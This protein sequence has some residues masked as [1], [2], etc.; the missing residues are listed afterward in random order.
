MTHISPP[1]L[2]NTDTPFNAVPFH[3]LDAS[4]IQQA[5]NVAY[6][7]A[8]KKFDCILKSDLPPSFENT[9]V[10][11]EEMVNE[12]SEIGLVLFNLNSAAT[13]KEIQNVSLKI[14]PKLTV[15][16]ARLYS[17][18]KL[19]KKVSYLYSKLSVLPISNEEKWIVELLWH[20]MKRNGANLNALSKFRLVHI[21]K[22]LSK[23][24]LHFNDNVLAE[25][26]N[27]FLHIKNLNELNGLHES[28]IEAAAAIAHEKNLEGWVFTLSYPSYSSFM[29]KAQNRVL[30][31][32][33]HKAYV[34]RCNRK[35]RYNN[36]GLLRKIVNLRL[37]QAQ[38]TGF[39]N[40]AQFVLNERMVET[41][42]AVFGFLNLLYD[43]SNESAISDFNDIK[44][45]AKSLDGIDELMPWD[46]A[47]YAEII[48]NEKFGFDDN[49]VKPYFRLENVVDAIFRLS[50]HLFGVQ[51]KQN[52]NIPTYHRDVKTYEV[53]DENGQFIA[54]L[55]LDFF[56]RQ[57]KQSGAWM[58]EYKQQSNIN[59]KMIRPHIS[60]C[61]NFS[62]PGENTPS[63]LTFYEVH[64]FLH[65]F[66][67]ALHGMF[68]NTKYPS[69]SGT[70]V[71]RDFVELPSQIME[72]WLY[73][74]EW[75]QQFAIHYKTSEAIPKELVNKLVE[76]R[77]FQTA[78]Q[79]QRQL[80]FSYLDMAWHTIT[81]PFKGNI[82]LFE[83]ANIEKTQVFPYIKGSSISASFSHIFGGGY[84]AGY[85]SYKWGEMLDADAYSLFRKNGIFDKETAQRFRAEILE[86]GGSAHPLTLYQNF[87]G[88]KPTIDALLERSKFLKPVAN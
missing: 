35:N 4:H 21:Q 47:F 46:Y 20:Q 49:I 23:M 26:N 60:V 55:Y 78:Y 7:K 34:S 58:T 29:K 73:E 11:L 10:P 71:Y 30:R 66:G 22:S 15:F 59:G 43:A 13:S 42:E 19:L 69:I 53:S 50:H 70:N 14:S 63:L 32:K 77:N 1:L 52:S 81:K 85:Y 61:C 37:E 44:L 65:E 5:F 79:T 33:M 83:R 86:K 74:H 24:T 38:I 8:K 39:S 40:Y 68:S 6:K 36:K 25:T 67:H 51:F 64:T 82:D 45:K 84:A 72:N 17:N 48:K 54:V 57:N 56:P 80:M 9:I 2:L 18:T 16:L 28:D 31:E 76:A 75:L 27:Y 62:K 3:L 41:P 88:K 87:R 12:L